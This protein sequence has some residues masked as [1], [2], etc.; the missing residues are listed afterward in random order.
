MKNKTVLIG[1]IFIFISLVFF[2]PIFNGKVPFPGDL[3]VGEYAPYDS[4]T[5]LGYAPH[6]YP[7][8][9]QDFDVLRLLYPEKEFSIRMSK[10]LEFP[11]WN[12]YNFSGNP[13][14]ASLQSGSF[15][16]LNL[17]FFLFPFVYAWT[18]FILIQP[19]LAMIFTF[20]FA[21]ELRL[22]IKSSIF[23]AITFAFS[24]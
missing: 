13:H 16:P 18:I 9:G 7:N 5:F 11:F 15:Y 1:L 24:S 2:Y 17:I 8:L 19:I 6:G 3:L 22:G 14:M 23:A 10:D 4:Y 12:P 20:L 21:R